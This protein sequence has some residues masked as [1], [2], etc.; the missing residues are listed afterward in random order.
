[1]A[2]EKNVEG[3]LNRICPKRWRSC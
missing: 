1:V 3:N 2:I